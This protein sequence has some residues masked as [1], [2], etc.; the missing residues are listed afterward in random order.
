MNTNTI[1]GL[2]SVI[3]PCF[4][5]REFTQ[6]CLQSLFRYTRAPWELIVV[7]N[8][9]TDDTRAYLAGVQ[10]ATAVPVTVVANATNLGFPAAINQGLQLAQGEYLV[11][12]NNDVVVT[13]GWLDQLIALVNAK[14]HL[15]AETAEIAE[16]K[17][18]SE[19]GNRTIIDF[20]ELRGEIERR[21]RPGPLPSP[22]I[23]LLSQGGDN[24]CSP[25]ESEARAE[26]ATSPTRG[27]LPSP[28]LALGC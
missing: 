13:E 17:T 10:D 8:G 25:S 11:L 28:P 16:T 23:A 27:P 7:D 18:A 26:T 12:L 2:A 19:N 6:L 15:T 21:S 3:V 24:I 5:Q 9:S 14:H 1:R 4:N 20:N 22:A